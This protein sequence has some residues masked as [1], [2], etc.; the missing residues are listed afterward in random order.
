MTFYI[1]IKHKFVN[2]T[3]SNIIKISLLINHGQHNWPYTQTWQKQ[4]ETWSQQ[5]SFEQNITASN[6]NDKCI[7]NII[8]AIE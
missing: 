1:N 4:E 6:R 3:T 8:L 5:P 7:K 2:I